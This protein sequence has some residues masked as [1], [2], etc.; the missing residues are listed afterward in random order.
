MIPAK[1]LDALLTDDRLAPVQR[2]IV[3]RIKLLNPGLN[4]VTHP[5]K[6]DLSELVSK[7]IVQSPGIGIG[8]SRIREAA[9]SDGAF[10]AAV[11]WVAYIVAEARLVGGK[12]I[13]KEAIGMA[14]GARLIEMLADLD[15][16]MW[17]LTGVLPPSDTP[18]PELKPLFT[19]RDAAQ[20]VAYYTVTWTQV[21]ADLGTPI[22]P[23]GTGTY[24]EARNVIQFADDAALG[25]ITKW[26]IA[27]EE[28]DNA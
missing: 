20:G 15:T 16:S 3:D 26:I 10:N 25:D 13:E 7:T 21:V 9:L 8:W 5:G 24:D 19:I 14:I 11:E 4:V 18:A 28:P 23:A 12:R 6:V 27:R 1:T 22:F 2:A 17:G